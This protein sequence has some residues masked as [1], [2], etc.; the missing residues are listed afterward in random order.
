MKKIGIYPLT[1]TLSPPEAEEGE[2]FEIKEND[3]PP[4]MG[5]GGGLVRAMNQKSVQTKGE[6]LLRIQNN[7]EAIRNLGVKK[8]GLFGSFIRGEQKTGSDIDLL[9][10]FEPGEKTF[11][12]FIHLSFLLEDLLQRPVEL[13]TTE[14]LSPYLRP[15]V[16]DEVED[17]PLSS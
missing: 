4:W 3:S 10:E 12:H 14:S 11:D 17:V 5:E 13:V 6:V 7:Q 1:L 16:L 15:Y 2:H 8:I 9:V